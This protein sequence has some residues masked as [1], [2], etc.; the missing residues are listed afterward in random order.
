MQVKT[1][2]SKD[3]IQLID[4]LRGFAIMIIF[5]IHVQEHFNIFNFPPVDSQ[6]AWLNNLDNSVFRLIFS[7]FAG[8]SYSI[9]ALLFGVT[10]YIQY[11]NQAKKGLDFG[12][13]FLWRMVILF[14]FGMLNSLFFPAGDILF[15][16]AIVGISLFIVRKW[17]SKTILIVAILLLA[18]PIEWMHYIISLF[19]ANYTMPNYHVDAYYKTVREV[20]NSGNLKDFF[21]TNMTT[22]ILGNM[23]WTISVGRL[24][25]TAGLFMLGYLIGCKQ[26]FKLEQ[27][28]IKFW[29]YVLI[30]AALAYNPLLEM[31]HILEARV[32]DTPI[33]V[34]TLCVIFD[35]W[36]KFAFTFVIVSAFVLLY[37]NRHFVSLTNKLCYMGRMTLTVY[38]LQ[39]LVGCFI[40]LP[41]GLGIGNYCGATVSLLISLILVYLQIV[42]CKWW[43]SSHKQGPLEAIWHKLT[44]I[45]TS[46]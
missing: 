23:L 5:I 44:W 43:L 42:F 20:A 6:P 41:V 25:Q 36:Q 24:L 17:K 13:H 1:S 39:G 27:K 30:F 46:K 33:L 12:P 2:L 34:G 35:M 28:N 10:F 9:F 40:F 22:G 31:R 21:Y 16:Y 3:R 11:N 4:A 15:I 8:K 32:G 38:I 18:Q 7:M 29:V 37:L 45:G 14:V 26:L 19:D